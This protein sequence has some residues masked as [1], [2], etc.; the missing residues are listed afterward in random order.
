[1]VLDPKLLDTARSTSAA[2][3]EAER[4]SLLARAEHHTAIRRLHLGGASLREIAA[5]LG[6]SHQRVAQIV[7]E[8]G[9]SWWQRV[10]HTRKVRRD[11]VCSFC[12]RPPREVEKLLAGPD[13]YLCSGCVSA[14]GRGGLP[15]VKGRAR[16]SFCGKARSEERPV[17]GANDARVCSAC[18]EVSKEILDGRRPTGTRAC[19]RSTP[20]AALSPSRVGRGP[21]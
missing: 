16:C 14:A 17:V 20:L 2:L 9:G 10:W 13:V 5:A 21:S 3:A 4:Q 15:M 1:M 7:D 18:L 11:A 12:G 8:A 6:L 19:A